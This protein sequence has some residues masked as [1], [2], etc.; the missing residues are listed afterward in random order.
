MCHMEE[1]MIKRPSFEVTEEMPEGHRGGERQA[2]GGQ[3][4]VHY[5]L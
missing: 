3:S 1:T 5:P 2:I 4:L